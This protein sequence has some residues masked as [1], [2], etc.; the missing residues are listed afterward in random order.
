M[1]MPSTQSLPQHV[2]KFYGP[3]DLNALLKGVK[4]FLEDRQYDFKETYK[5]KKSAE[6][7]KLEAGWTSTVKA[8]SFVRKSIKIAFFI[9]EIRDIEVVIDGKKTKLQHGRGLIEINGGLEFSYLK[10]HPW[11]E[12][13]LDFYLTYI[14]KPVYLGKW[15]DNHWYELQDLDAL[16][17][18]LLDFEVK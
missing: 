6:G 18:Q 12:K 5:M 9:L 8:T 3:F 2:I 13:M 4:K 17:R 11:N 16:C 7:W 15:V 10:E 14:Y 1:G